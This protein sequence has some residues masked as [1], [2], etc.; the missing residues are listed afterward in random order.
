MTLA[1]T[2]AAGLIGCG[3]VGAQEPSE[4]EMREAMLYEMN[5]P[6]GVTVTDPVSIKFFKKEA[7]DKPT[8]QGYN[9]TFTVQV[10]S[11]NMLAGMYANLPSANFYKD[12]KGKWQMRPPF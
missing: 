9:C 1:A 5:H 12:D 8:P 4:A 3:S 2:L 6:P 7:C 11:A 10:V